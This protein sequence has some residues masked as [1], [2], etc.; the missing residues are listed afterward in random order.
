MTSD[1]GR[2]GGAAGGAADAGS[3][4]GPD[5][6]HVVVVGVDGSAGSS[7]A[8]RWAADEARAHHAALRVV[9]AWVL[10]TMIYPAYGP[11]SMYEDMPVQAEAR[12]RAQV[13][14]VLGADPGVPV[15]VVV[16][17]GRPAEVVLDEA[18]GADMVVVGSRGRGGFAGLLLG[19]V[20]TQVVHHAACPVVVV[21]R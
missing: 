7:D 8:L 14:E 12:A 1:V 9:H 17:E 2:Q 13:D 4:P 6:G 19:S 21:R 15:D 16:R 18:K 5:G 3:E 11:A 20:S 10:P